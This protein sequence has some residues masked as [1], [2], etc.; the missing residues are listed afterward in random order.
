MKETGVLNRLFQELRIIYNHSDADWLFREVKKLMASYGKD[1]VILEKRKKYQD[2]IL[3][4]EKD[5]ILI[6]YPDAIRKEGEKPLKTLLRFLEKRVKKSITGIHIL[7]FFPSSSDGGYAV[8]NYK[9][10]DPRLG[11]WDDIQN[12]SRDYR[13]MVD[14]VLNHASSKSAWFQNFLEGNKD[15]R[16]Y[17]ISYDKNLDM[18][19]VFRPRET[20]LLTPFET[21][22]GEKWLWTTFGA[23][24]IDLN[25]KTPEV[26]LRMIGI[27][28]FYLSKGVEIIR[29]DA[30]G[31]VWKE[32]GTSCVN[33]SKTHQIVRVFR[34]ILE[35]VAP[36][37][38][39]LT[40]ANFPYKENVAYFGEGHEANMVYMFSLPP[41]VIDAFAR[42]DTTYIRE[43]TNRT[44]QELLFF[45]FLASHDGVPLLSAKKLLRPEHFGNLL[46]LTKK[47]NGYISYKTKNGIEEPY[48]LNISYLDA[49]DDPNIGDD[50][51]AVKRFVASQAIMLSLKGIPGIYLHSLL[52]SRNYYEGVEDSGEKRAINR[53]K[54]W[55]QDIDTMLANEDCLSHRVYYAMIKLIDASR[56]IRALHPYSTKQVLDSD[57]RLLVIRREFE[58]EAVRTIINVSE[59]PL[60]A[61]DYSGKKDLISH[62]MFNGSIE[63]Y[64]VYCIESDPSAK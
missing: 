64:G 27:F 50:P 2:S 63:P 28:L 43:I 22:M 15:Y 19:K 55:E 24:Q 34:S 30:I 11:D 51:D 44:R 39:I 12:I 18:P 53:Q 48:E 8:I 49:I 32:S 59:D 54:L 6:T 36:Y 17:F 5:S 9:E 58:G 52:G 3:L 4:D 10:V 47:H 62:E 42:K 46:E 31:Y 40:E 56:K 37:A 41:L 57:R 14:L 16:D 38:L 1:A 23:D 13:L 7:P 25:F 33:L 26:L 21:A 35:Y 61:M 29:L 60:T 45:E 20:P